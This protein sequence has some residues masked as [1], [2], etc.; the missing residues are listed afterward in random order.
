MALM[1]PP[2]LH[3]QSVPAIPPRAEA[4]TEP[5]ATER[6]LKVDSPY[7]AGPT[8]IRVLLPARLEPGKQ[9]P[10][11][12]VL[13]VE[14]AGQSRYGVGLR[15]VA[16]HHLPDRWSAVFVA[17]EF[18]HL[19]WYADHPSDPQIRQESHLLKVVLPE[20]EQAFPVRTDAAGRLLLG[21]SKSGWGA[22]SLLLRH[23]DRFG[24]AAAWD[25]PLMMDRIGLYGTRDI[26]ASQEQFDRYRPDL[27]LRSGAL[28]SEGEP[29]L[30]LTGYGN[31]RQHH[32]QAHRLLSDL[33]IPHLHRDGP[34][35]KH[36]WH[37]GWVEEA[38]ELL[39]APAEREARAP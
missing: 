14:A 29:R 7:Q 27:L 12:Y 2:C 20:V 36:D 8:R 35:R 13:P 10:T 4:D 6:I 17:P 3:A 23:P 18:S 33:R 21:F 38:A 19:P 15:E 25:A 16:R 34:A 24:R 32:Q 31:F 9:Y 22:W 1:A 37:S 39:L 30:I 28:R 26:L 11:V 5:L